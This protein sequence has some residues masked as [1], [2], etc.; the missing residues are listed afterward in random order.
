MQWFEYMSYFCLFVYLQN[1]HFWNKIHKYSLRIKVENA[2]V[3]Q[4]SLC[5]IE[6]K[7]WNYRKENLILKFGD[8]YCF[9]EIFLRKTT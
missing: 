1:T 3:K 2:W 8:L 6:E 7:E 4:L 9:I 5:Q